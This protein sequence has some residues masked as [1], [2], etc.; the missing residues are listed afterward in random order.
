MFCPPVTELFIDLIYSGAKGAGASAN[1]L[2][3]L[4]PMMIIPSSAASGE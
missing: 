2:L 3:E 4:A 1:A